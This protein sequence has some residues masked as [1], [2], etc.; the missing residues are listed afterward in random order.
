MIKVEPNKNI[1][2]ITLLLNS[3]FPKDKEKFPLYKK[4]Y[5]KFEKLIPSTFWNEF[6]KVNRGDSSLSLLYRY[7]NLSFFLDNNFEFTFTKEE[8]EEFC[9][10]N[11]IQKYIYFIN[12]SLK[13]LYKEIDFDSFYEEN[14]Q[15]GY[16]KLCEDINYIFLKK[17]N[18]E[19]ELINFWEQN[20]NLKLIF[21][22]NFVSLGDCFG[23]KRGEIFYSVTSPKINVQTGRSEYSPLHVYS[24]TIH[25]FSHSFLKESI[26]IDYSK[27]ELKEKL[28]R[29]SLDESVL[30]VY[31]IGYFEEC[32]VRACTMRIK[33]ILNV[34]DL[35][36]V[37]LEEKVENF[38]LSNDNLG[39]SLV[40]IFYD[41]LLIK[42][43]NSL[44]EIFN[45]VLNHI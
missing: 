17:T 38:L 5:K 19:K 37:E 24:N 33:E 1:I 3:K 30:K 18:I 26:K 14:I 29:L 42:R 41:R 44:Q 25:E 8:N 6:D 20:S 7:I 40:R 2:F 43:R 35:D 21:I 13:K 16:V 9:K 45:R 28:N 12:T 23:F 4:I 36:K 15:E 39:Y 27:E 34:Y 10:F 11:D 32:F 31:G 22:P